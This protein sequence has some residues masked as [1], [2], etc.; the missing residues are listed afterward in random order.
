MSI[1]EE[2][3]AFAFGVERLGKNLSLMQAYMVAQPI[4]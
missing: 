3:A 4:F 1:A 2:P